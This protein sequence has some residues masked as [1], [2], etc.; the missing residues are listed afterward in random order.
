VGKW[1]VVRSVGRLEKLL[2]S[3]SFAFII[4]EGK[5][6]LTASF[7]WAW[8]NW[9][10]NEGIYTYLFGKVFVLAIDFTD[11]IL[12]WDLYNECATIS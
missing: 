12:E 7:L 11:E 2:Q 6:D 3:L 1:G 8:V 4:G 5:K 9:K 10:V